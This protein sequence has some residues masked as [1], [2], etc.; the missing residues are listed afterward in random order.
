[1]LGFWIEKNN[2]YPG[3]MI[4]NAKQLE[5]KKVDVNGFDFPVLLQ[6]SGV[7]G[8]LSVTGE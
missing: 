2:A 8:W 3:L 5:S 6:S 1:M 7:K 4:F